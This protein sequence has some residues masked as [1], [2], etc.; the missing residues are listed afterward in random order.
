MFN[1]P[2]D[3]DVIGVVVDMVDGTIGVLSAEPEPGTSS[4]AA[5]VESEEVLN[6]AFVAMPMDAVDRPFPRARPDQRSCSALRHH[7]GTGRRPRDQRAHYRSRA[8]V[9]PAR[10]VRDRRPGQ[11]Q[12]ERL[13]REAGY[14]HT[15]GKAP[16]YVAREGTK[17]EFDLKDFPVIFFKNYKQLKDDLKKPLRG[18]PA[19]NSIAKIARDEIA[20]SY[21]QRGDLRSGAR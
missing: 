18:P 21:V 9:E 4:T 20:S 7:G 2:W 12:A 13:L 11:L 15:L 19:E 1:P 8:R 14:A 17:L 3:L 6:Y 5:I 10:R 16:I